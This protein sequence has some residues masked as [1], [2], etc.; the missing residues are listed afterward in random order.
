MRHL[1]KWTVSP[2]P[3]GRYRS[4]EHRSWPT[5]DYSDTGETAVALYSDRDYSSRDKE[6]AQITICV[7]DWRQDR[8][9]TWRT[10]K[11]RA[12]GLT[13]AKRLATDFLTAHPELR[14]PKTGE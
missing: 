9:F 8:G 4:F 3:T 14:Q 5:A 7:A 6:T 11:T 10:L 12:T 1:L 2:V 13:E